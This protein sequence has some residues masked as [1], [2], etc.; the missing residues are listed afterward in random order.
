MGVEYTIPT[1][2]WIWL[3]SPLQRPCS[4]VSE[5]LQTCLHWLLCSQGTSTLGA[6]G[7]IASLR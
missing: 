3:I 1:N 2:E 7:V 4:E 5:G 6:G